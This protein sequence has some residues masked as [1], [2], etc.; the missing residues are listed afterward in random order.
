MIAVYRNAFCVSTAD[1]IGLPFLMLKNG[2]SFIAIV[3]VGFS[4]KIP[5]Q[6]KDLV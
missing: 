4:L 2:T 6:I 3:I 1:K 5:Y